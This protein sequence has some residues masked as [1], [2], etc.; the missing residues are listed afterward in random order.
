MQTKYSLILLLA[1]LV[2]SFAQADIWQ[3]ARTHSA[4]KGAMGAFG[5][6]YIDPVDFNAFV[7]GTYGLNPGLQ[8]E[9]R[10]GVG[11]HTTY[12]GGFAKQ[13]ITELGSAATFSLWGGVH[14]QGSTYVDFAP[15]FSRDFST[16]EIYVAPQLLVKIVGPADFLA[17]AFNL[18]G[19][20][21]ISNGLRAYMEFTG[22]LSKYYNALSGG[23]RYFF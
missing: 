10:L 9:A 17:L 16:V 6:L 23:V 2:S 7:N 13:Y 18:G 22:N 3:G 12:L 11:T 21:G 19:S 1:L 14:H 15:I 5:M 8:A 20:V 4:G